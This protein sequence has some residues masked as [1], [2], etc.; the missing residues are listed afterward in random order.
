MSEIEFYGDLE[1]PIYFD[2]TTSQTLVID[3]S[4]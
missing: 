1:I 3:E 4:L 2:I